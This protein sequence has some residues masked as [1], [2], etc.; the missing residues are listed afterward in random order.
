[1]SNLH[2]EALEAKV[3]GSMMISAEDCMMALSAITTSEVF[4][5][6][7][8][9]AVFESL[10]RL[11]EKE[12]KVDAAAIV[13][14]LKSN[15]TYE[16]SGGMKNL[17][18]T[19]A[20]GSG[21]GHTEVHARILI[22]M[23]IRRKAIELGQELITKASQDEVDVFAQIASMQSQTEKLIETSVGGSEETFGVIISD[24]ERKWLRGAS[25]GLSGHPTGLEELDRM[26]GGLTPGELTI[27][28]ARPGQGKTA[29]VV[30]L[31][32]NLCHQNIPC[33][34]FSLEMS[35]HELAQRLASQESQVPA[36][37]I[38]GGMLTDMEKSVLRSARER[39][40]NWNIRIF[41]EGEMN[42]RKLRA[43]AMVWQKRHGMQV[44]FVDYLQLMSGTDSKRQNRENEISEISR[45]LKILA[46]ELNIPVVALS[47][48][49]RRVEERGDKMPQLSD[50]RESGAIEQDADVV[51]FLMRPAYYKM[52]GD[53]EINGKKYDLNDVCIIDQAKMRSG[54]TGQIPLM[55]D[56]PL[57][58]MRAYDRPISQF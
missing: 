12:I 19:M 39:M 53:V 22:E 35:R 31:I 21:L 56:G 1:M 24:T 16:S 6:Y 18:K 10:R 42:L 17:T 14:D 9:R 57:M 20:S 15:G 27:V 41:D 38:K 4:Y 30:S 34:I 58:R 48:L 55:F 28:G 44:L 52:S 7:K 23:F 25:N 33:G 43:R 50:L 13:H 36:F 11:T 46:R 37:K 40:Q 26:C 2:D 32:R 29:L 54:N 45:G 51:W 47:Q 3:L 5:D 8:N 49:S